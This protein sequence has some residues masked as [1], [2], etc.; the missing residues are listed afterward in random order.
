[1]IVSLDTFRVRCARDHEPVELTGQAAV[2]HMT[3]EHGAKLGTVPTGYGDPRR[4]VSWRP[5]SAVVKAL[6]WKAPRQAPL[7]A[8]VLAAVRD[9]DVTI[10]SSDDFVGVDDIKVGDTFKIGP[11]VYTL[12]DADGD[13]LTVK[14]HKGSARHQPERVSPISRSH[15]REQVAKISENTGQPLLLVKRGKAA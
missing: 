10:E 12:L 13:T 11:R 1:M 2:E 7:S 8:A 14:M 9:G 3:R 6:P 4:F 15:F 5:S